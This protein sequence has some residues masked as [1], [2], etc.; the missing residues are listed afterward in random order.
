MCSGVGGWRWGE[1]GWLPERPTICVWLTLRCWHCGPRGPGWS[2][3]LSVLVTSHMPRLCQVELLS[4]QVPGLPRKQKQ[5]G[6]EGPGTPDFPFF[7]WGGRVVSHPLPAPS[8]GAYLSLCPRTG[9]KPECSEMLSDP[10]GN[11]LS[12]YCALVC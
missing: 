1:R 4:L 6:E 12:H 9:G 5:Q 10:R 8:Q 3:F 7:L 11:T 2:H